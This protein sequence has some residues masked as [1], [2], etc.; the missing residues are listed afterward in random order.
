VLFLLISFAIFIYWF[1]TNFG[2]P[3]SK[4]WNLVW[5]CLNDRIWF[6]PFH[7][8]KKMDPAFTICISKKR[9]RLSPPAWAKKRIPLSPPAWAKNRMCIRANR[10]TRAN[11][12]NHAPCKELL[13]RDDWIVEFYYPILSC[14][15]K[16][17][18]VSV[19][20]NVLVE[21]ILSVSETIQKCVVMQNIH[22]LC[23]VYFSL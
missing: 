8:A 6:F 9:I 20:N 13:T 10:S 1:I 17:K 11:P 2:I 14:F 23:C 19:P 12:A 3:L 18:S 4:H 5:Q 21:F 7:P 15:W 22:L 16:M